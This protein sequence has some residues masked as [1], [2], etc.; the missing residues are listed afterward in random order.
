L[1][2]DSPKKKYV[3]KNLLL[4][5]VSAVILWIFVSFVLKP[6]KPQEIIDHKL[7]LIAEL[8][9]VIKSPLTE[10]LILPY[11]HSNKKFIYRIRETEKLKAISTALKDVDPSGIPG[12]TPR[13]FECILVIKTDNKEK[14]YLATVNGKKKRHLYLS[15]VFSK[16][17]GNNKYKS[18]NPKPIRVKNFGTWLMEVA[19]E[20][21]L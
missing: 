3:R 5:L 8:Q 13:L 2:T 19:P 4:I 1:S 15:N 18:Q 21:I 6:E 11:E 12:H 20:A 17:V 7:A 10:V 16:P 14:K 9:E